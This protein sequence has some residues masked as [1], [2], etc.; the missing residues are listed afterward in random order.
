LNSSL[1]SVHILVY[2]LYITLYIALYQFFI[3]CIAHLLYTHTERKTNNQNRQ[4]PFSISNVF[5]SA[6]LTA[7]CIDSAHKVTQEPSNR[8]NIKTMLLS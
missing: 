4:K 1:Y 7:N 8:E 5:K 6:H 3:I 2:Y